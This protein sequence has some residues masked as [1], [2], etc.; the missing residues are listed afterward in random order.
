MKAMKILSKKKY[1]ILK[2]F[3]EL[4]K[5]KNYKKLMK[6]KHKILDYNKDNKQN[7]RNH[8]NNSLSIKI[9]KALYNHVHNV[10]YA[11]LKLL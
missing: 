3:I 6:V 1:K 8:N 11:I 7:N 5:I 4:I 10:S 2:K 9:F